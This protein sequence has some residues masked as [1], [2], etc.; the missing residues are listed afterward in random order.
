L[1]GIVNP[2]NPFQR[3]RARFGPVAGTDGCH[4]YGASGMRGNS[5]GIFLQ[6]AQRSRTDC[7]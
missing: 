6:Q 3:A 7:S 2:T 4:G 1:T 5:I